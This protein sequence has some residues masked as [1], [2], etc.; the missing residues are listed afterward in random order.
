ML[1]DRKTGFEYCSETI[2]SALRPRQP[3][4]DKT[5]CRRI[6]PRSKL[7]TAVA[8]S[9]F[10]GMTGSTLAQ[11]ID[12]DLS[13]DEFRATAEEAYVYAFPMLVAYKV[14]H[15]YNV[16]QNSGAFLAPFNQLHNEARVFSPKDTT[17][18]TP[19][20]DTPYSMVQLDLRAEPMVFC[21]PAGR[22]VPLLQRAI[23]RH[24]H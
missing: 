18:V 2:F 7:W 19:N 5:A 14:L 20:S 1:L 22:Q 4:A 17:I 24:V 3:D 8:G 6:G 12:P 11:T 16:D 23:D 21:L 10:L 9:A 15:D 13:I